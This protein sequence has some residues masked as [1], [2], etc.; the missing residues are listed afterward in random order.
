MGF[1]FF[2]I[3]RP[4]MR[5]DYYEYEYCKPLSKQEFIYFNLT[6]DYKKNSTLVF[7]TER[8]V[9]TPVTLTEEESSYI[10]D[11]IL[12]M[13]PDY[14]RD[15]KMSE[16]QIRL[17]Y[18]QLKPLLKELEH[19]L[20][21]NSFYYT[22]FKWPVYGMY[23]YERY[24]EE[25]FKEHER[26]FLLT[27]EH[28][29]SD[30]YARVG[31]DAM[32]LLLGFLCILFSFR[33]FCEEKANHMEAYIFT[34]NISSVRY[35]LLKYFS[36]LTPITFFSFLL[37]LLEYFS[38][39][40]WNEV[41]GYG[42]DIEFLSF[43]KSTIYIIVPSIAVIIGLS[44][45]LGILFSNSLYTMILQFLFYFFSISSTLEKKYGFSFI[46]RFGE[47]DD[48][49]SY[50]RYS[51]MIVYNRFAIMLLSVLFL[52]ATV[53]LFQKKRTNGVV[54]HPVKINLKL[55]K[56]QRAQKEHCLI[57]YLFQQIAGWNLV[58]Y[59]AYI[60]I[61]FLVVVRENMDTG[62]IATIGENIVLF[63]AFF[64]YI[65]ISNYDY[66]FGIHGF[67][68]TAKMN[69]VFIIA[70]RLILTSIILFIFVEIPIMFLCII[71]RV[72]MGR[73]CLGVYI[74]ALCIG[75]SSLLIAEISEERLLGY[76]FFLCYYYFNV[77]LED[78]LP[79]SLLGYTFKIKN[80]K[81]VLIIFIIFLTVLYIS[82]NISKSKGMGLKE[83]CGSK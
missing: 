78:S 48:Y 80:T 74:S 57:Y 31:A 5:Q 71:N 69:P 49:T 60:I 81:Y 10:Y 82:C 45:V 64:L 20:R 35:V 59:V 58:I 13:N 77:L 63:A 32:G 16:V 3:I 36:I 42:Y 76:F 43:I 1:F 38:F 9:P 39:M 22:C 19:L 28:G 55:F 67:T 6:K 17:K 53:Y 14:R 41:Y 75:V 73:W 50:K 18:S 37:T 34:S 46:V 66:A 23:Q 62:D 12:K 29:I 68:N 8:W 33:V 70:A 83:I 27:Y 52:M 4:D 7:L 15:E 11:I 65:K 56:I 2:S 26:N 25:D 61:M 72:Q 54:L 79:F 30:A 40:G 47:Y 21:A 44:M 51:S 24:Q